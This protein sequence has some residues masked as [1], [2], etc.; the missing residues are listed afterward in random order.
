MC[1]ILR[2][3]DPYVLSLGSTTPDRAAAFTTSR[4]KVTKHMAQKTIVQLIDDLDG[5]SNGDIETV[6]F[7]LDGVSYEI[8]LND[9]H[10]GR[11]REHLAKFITSARRTGGRVKRGTT[12]TAP[13]TDGAGRSRE[14]TQAI[15]EWA[16]KNGYEVSARGRIPAAVIEAF[17]AGAGQPKTRKA[18]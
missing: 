2:P 15:R 16:R 7:G 3:P 4:K 13:H 8:D 9:D 18:R 5:T 6:V 14:Q 12:A 17:E 11:L 10:A 1:H